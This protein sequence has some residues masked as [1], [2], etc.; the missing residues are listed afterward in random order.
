[1]QSHRHY[2]ATIADAW[3]NL[4]RHEAERFQSS[5]HLRKYALIKCGYA[6]QRQIVCASKAEAQRLR[7][8]VAP[9]DDYAIVTAVESVVTVFT[10]KSQSTKAMG[11]REFN[12]SKQR[13]LDYVSQILGVSTDDLQKAEA[14]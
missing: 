10:A 11:R 7:A 2:F 8:F 5:E 4:P 12:E 1:M 6:D 13:V 9:M 14:A 3:Q